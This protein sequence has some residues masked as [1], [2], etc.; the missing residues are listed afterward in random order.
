MKKYRILFL[1]AVAA[2]AAG[3][4]G[5]DTNLDY[6]TLDVPTIEN[7][8]KD[9]ALF[10][11]NNKYTIPMSDP[12]IIT[13]NVVY[14]D[15]NDL[16]YRWIING[17][18]VATTKDLNWMWDVAD[19]N[20]VIGVYEIH[21]NSAGNSQ[22][23]S[24][25]VDLETPFAIGYSVLVERDG[26]LQYDFIEEYRTGQALYKYTYHQNAAG[27]PLVF[28]GDN[29]RLQEYWSCQGGSII[30]GKQM[31]L[32]EDPNNCVS[33]D[34]SSLL[35]EM[36]LSQ[37]FIND[38]LPDDFRVRDFMHGG[39]VSYLLADDGRI[40]SRKGLRIFY[41][42]R[43]SDLPLQ[44]KGK[45]IKG[46]KFVTPKYDQDYGLIYEETEEGGRFLLV[47]FD[48]DT[49]ETY[50]PT[51]AG[52]IL[53]FEKDANLNGITDYEFVEGWFVLLNNPFAYGEPSSIMMLFRGKTDPGKY[54][55]REVQ[56]GFEAR[57]GA[58]TTKEVF[59]EIYRELPDFG[60]GSKMAVLQVDGGSYFKSDYIF[61][62][63]ASDPRKV[64]SRER[65]GIAAPSDF[66]TFD[67][68]VVTLISGVSKRNNCMIFFA[69]ADGTIMTYTPWNSK[70]LSGKANFATFEQERIVSQFQTGGKVRW[71]SFK[72]GGFATFS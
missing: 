28:S 69:L 50:N 6:T 3:C 21:R 43:F 55:I 54:Y 68:E 12:L 35:Q 62:T 25:S 64:L 53:E 15:M 30:I 67:Q 52:Q 36:K 45:Q 24:F 1:A 23:Y 2:L 44:Y 8:D 34:G 18:E 37:E 19:A 14:K 56:I 10:V 72:Y 49:Q 61:Y 5:D 13:P 66:H 20:H 22:I 38:E 63:A 65:K 58:I 41:T 29:P 59:S 71:V 48:F 39:F 17:K 47:N 46:K 31:F 32:D 70:V 51:K 16:S 4:Y 42:G 60:P 9:P 57:T 33:L 7:P 40:F 26:E 27:Q 11:E